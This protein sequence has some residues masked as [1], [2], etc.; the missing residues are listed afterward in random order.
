MDPF[1]EAVLA[2]PWAVL[3]AYSFAQLKAKFTKCL[4]PS[5]GCSLRAIKAHSIQ[6]SG[7]LERVSR[8]GHVVS[9]RRVL[10]DG[11]ATLDFAEE[12]RNQAT[13]FTGLCAPHDAEIFRPIE[14]AAIDVQ[15]EQHLFLL[16]YRA[17]LKELHT[18]M[19]W[20]AR[21]QRI[22]MKRVALGLSPKG[23]PDPPGMFAT[24]RLMASYITHLYK[25]KYD[26]AFLKG[27]FSAVSHEVIVFPKQA[28]TIAVNSLT[29]DDSIRTDEDVA[30]VAVNVF[31][32][33]EDVVAVFS[34]LSG[35]APQ[36][37]Q[38]HAEVSTATGEYQKYALSRLLLRCC[39]NFVLNPNYFDRMPEAKK[40]AIRTF[41]LSTISKNDTGAHDPDLFLF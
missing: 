38:F 25:A 1:P 12:G 14:T 10:R 13:T 23:Q 36:A 4:E 28:A 2:D 30:R 35:E 18:I 19:E 6:N 26:E 37:R 17:V 31:P 9:M 21:L 5:A 16:S 39:E 29:S 20:A 11:K 33:G 32:R 22:Y 41:F 15:N 8:N 3:K 27:N 7:I 34:Y 24:E 40:G